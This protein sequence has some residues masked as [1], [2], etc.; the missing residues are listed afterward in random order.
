MGRVSFQ[1]LTLHTF[2]MY[3]YY[4]AVNSGHNVITPTA[5]WIVFMFT[6]LV[7]LSAPKQVD[8]ETGEEFFKRVSKSSD[9]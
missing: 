7:S 2:S 4:C 5:A 6:V 8:A 9:F 3:G 1:I